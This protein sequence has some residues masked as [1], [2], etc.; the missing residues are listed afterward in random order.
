MVFSSVTF[1]LIFL[2]VTSV[3]YYIPN[4]FN[5]KNKA[6]GYKN[7]VLCLVSLFFYA[8]G[9]PVNVVLLLISIAFNYT[10]ARDMSYRTKQGKKNKALLVFSLIFNIGI[11]GFYKYGGFIVE[12]IASVFNLKISYFAPAL[13]I[14]ISFFTFQI[15]SYVIDV[16]NEK[17]EALKNVMDF[18]LYISMFPQ[19]VAGPIVQYSQ[20]QKQLRNRQENIEEVS[21]GICMF[22]KGLFKKTV[23]A[24]AA[25]AIYEVLAAEGFGNLSVLGSWS[26]VIF[27]AFQIYY[28]FSGYSDMAMGLGAM[29]GFKLPIN[30][31]HPYIAS[32][33]TDFWHRWHIT[34][35]SWF[36]DY[37]YI[38]MGGSHRS[39]ARNIFNLFV[40]WSLTGFWHGA[41]WNFILWGVY[42]FILLVFEKYILKSFLNKIPKFIRQIF[43]FILVLFGWVLFSCTNLVDCISLFLAMFGKN[44]FMDAAGTYVLLTNAVILFIMGIASTGLFSY[45]KKENEKGL[46]TVF[47]HVFTFALLFVSIMCL[48]GDSYNP[49]LYFRF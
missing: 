21:E 10:V 27:Y 16:Y 32:S 49:F 42:Y 38:P 20:I 46:R 43:T 39:I 1:L 14:G 22:V 31:N 12:N 4:L 47:R 48:A 19:L 11:L 44:G 29:F 24:N 40:V 23:F 7:A 2:L 41:S 28:D 9:E 13:P 33:V 18:S 6:I 30:F 25:G 37:V 5:K 8:W 34:L 17:N 36:K 35:S 15:L 26:A 3:F 45:E